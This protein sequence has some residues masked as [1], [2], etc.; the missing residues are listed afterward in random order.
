MKQNYKLTFCSRYRKQRTWTTRNSR[1][2]CNWI[3]WCRCGGCYGFAWWKWWIAC[4]WWREWVCWIEW[5]WWIAALTFRSYRSYRHVSPVFRNTSTY[6]CTVPALWAFSVT[7]VQ[8]SAVSYELLDTTH[9]WIC[10]SVFK[11]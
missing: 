2:S 5:A 10:S 8:R 3:S 1:R 7:A 6:T 11:C 4:V 9:Q